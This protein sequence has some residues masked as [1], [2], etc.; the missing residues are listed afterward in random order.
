M[1]LDNDTPTTL[2]SLCHDFFVATATQPRTLHKHT[3]TTK[4]TSTCTLHEHYTQGHT[5]THEDDTKH[6]NEMSMGRK[7][8]TMTGIEN[9]TVRK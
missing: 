1:H 2:T 4:N 6:E 9:D 8:R 5:R 3:N 7:L